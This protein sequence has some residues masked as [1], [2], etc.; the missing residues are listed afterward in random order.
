MQVGFGIVRGKCWTFPALSTTTTKK[1][2][3]MSSVL[4]LLQLLPLL[5]WPLSSSSPPS[6]SPPLHSR[7]LRCRRCSTRSGRCCPAVPDGFPCPRVVPC[8]CAI[9]KKKKKFHSV[10]Y[11]IRTYM[12]CKFPI[13]RHSKSSSQSVHACVRACTKKIFMDIESTERPIDRVSNFHRLVKKIFFQEGKVKWK[14]DRSIHPS[15]D[16]WTFL[17]HERKTS[18]AAERKKCQHD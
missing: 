17:M 15:L 8:I 7:S 1:T 11:I 3:P 2:R 9:S 14:V 12:D 5:P 4:V 16:H 13:E 18:T 6:S 10:M